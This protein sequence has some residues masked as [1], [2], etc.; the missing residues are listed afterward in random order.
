MRIKEVRKKE[1]ETNHFEKKFPESGCFF[2]RSQNYIKKMRIK[3]V[4][5]KEYETNHELA[6]ALKML[7]SLVF[8][9]KK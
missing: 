4:R 5:K 1:Y 3:E 8:E 2:H 6:L 7:P 9:K